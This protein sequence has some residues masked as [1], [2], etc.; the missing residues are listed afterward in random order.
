MDVRI[1]ECTQCGALGFRCFVKEHTVPVTEGV[2][3]YTSLRR[4]DKFL[5]LKSDE[6]I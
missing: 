2:C 5:T 1:G 6:M 3:A 4:I